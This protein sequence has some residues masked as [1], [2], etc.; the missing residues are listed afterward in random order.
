RRVLRRARPGAAQARL[1][2]ARVQ[3]RSRARP[4]GDHLRVRGRGGRADVRRGTV[5]GAL[6]PEDAVAMRPRLLLTL[7]ALTVVALGVGRPANAGHECDGLDVCVSVTGPWVV[8]P[9]G[10]K[11]PTY[12]QLRCP[13]RG[14]IVGGL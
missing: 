11:T 6:V 3:A 4:A 5:L 7:A 9:T 8:V 2:A 10:A 1:R 14:M 13:R 12:Y